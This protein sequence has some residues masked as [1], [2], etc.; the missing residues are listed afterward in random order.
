MQWV[1][2]SAHAYLLT[3]VLQAQPGGLAAQPPFSLQLTLALSSAAWRAA[4]C[5]AWRAERDL[6][7]LMGMVYPAQRQ[8]PCHVS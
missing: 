7:W 4:F 3:V 1:A 5:A 8:A 2:A 6:L